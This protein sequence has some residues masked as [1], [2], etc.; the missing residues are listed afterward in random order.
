MVGDIKKKKKKKKNNA[1]LL[2]TR[3]GIVVACIV[4][5]LPPTQRERQV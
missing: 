4:R 3:V 5:R 2:G 1:H